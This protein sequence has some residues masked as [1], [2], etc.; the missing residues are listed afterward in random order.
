MFGV[1]AC[2]LVGRVGARGR[3]SGVSL[4]VSYRSRS[5]RPVSLVGVKKPLLGPW[6]TMALIAGPG[7]LAVAVIASVNKCDRPWHCHMPTDPV[8]PNW[9][10]I[11]T[12]VFTF[13]LSVAAILALDAVKES[14]NAR[15]AEHMAD[16]SR[17][18]DEAPFLEVRRKVK[19]YADIGLDSFDH[20]APP[21]PYRFMESVL[22]L[23]EDNA[24]DYWKLLTD[25]NFLENLAILVNRGGMDYELVNDSL[26][27]TVPYR[28]SL[29]QPSVQYWRT[30]D[31]NKELYMN[32]ETLALKI[33]AEESNSM[34]TEEVVEEDG[35][36]VERV[37]WVGFME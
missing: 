37:K 25:P 21:G 22:K 24:S 27:Y 6:V 3:A 23:G 18:W 7:L 13:V 4:G 30:R 10:E 2:R 26:G 36:V 8:G 12:A 20:V 14:R 17:R 34:E 35:K 32:F 11:L 5:C 29:W 15:N 31:H 19:R 1:C 33:A 28:W 16:L 9:A